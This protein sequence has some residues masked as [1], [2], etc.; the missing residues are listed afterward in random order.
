[1]MTCPSL[2]SVTQDGAYRYMRELNNT[3]N[4]KEASMIR[5]QSLERCN[6]IKVKRT[7]RKRGHVTESKSLFIS[8]LLFYKYVDTCFLI[9]SFG[10]LPGPIDIETLPSDIIKKQ[11]L[12]SF[13]VMSICLSFQK[14][15]IQ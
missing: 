3:A 7:S 9:G 10:V 8:F 14:F 11:K 13:K 1:M 12:L 6:E 5:D 15:L 4:K 2:K